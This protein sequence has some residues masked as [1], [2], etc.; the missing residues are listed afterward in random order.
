MIIVSI[1]RKRVIINR[2][3]FCWIR[4]IWDIQW[5]GFKV[6][7][8]EYELMK[9]TRFLCLALM[10]KYTSKKNGSDGLALGY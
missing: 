3:I 7:I 5:I 8:I 6:K 1:K 2:K 9:L 4:N 10:I